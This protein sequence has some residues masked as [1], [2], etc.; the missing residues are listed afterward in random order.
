MGWL[1][2][3]TF[4]LDRANGALRNPARLNVNVVNLCDAQI[5]LTSTLFVRYANRHE[6]CEIQ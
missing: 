3:A 5:A 6:I 2:G 4:A 1:M